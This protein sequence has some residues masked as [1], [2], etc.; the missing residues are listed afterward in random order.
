M[1][2]DSMAAMVWAE[3][4]DASGGTL[5]QIVVQIET[6]TLSAMAEHCG[7]AYRRAFEVIAEQALRELLHLRA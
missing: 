7:Y 1:R 3:A 4:I 2:W 6:N 5:M